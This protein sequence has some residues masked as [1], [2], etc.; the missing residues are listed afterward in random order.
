[1][2]ANDPDLGAMQRALRRF[3]DERDWAQYHAPR[4]LAMALSVEA[5]ELLGNRPRPFGR[6]SR[7]TRRAIRW[8]RHAAACA[9]TNATVDEA[10]KS[11]PA[12]GFLAPASDVHLH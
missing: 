7:R 9:S 1:M 6:S 2:K 8:K 3:N 5:S 11:A 12:A 4:N 10:E